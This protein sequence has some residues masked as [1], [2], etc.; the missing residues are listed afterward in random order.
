MYELVILFIIVFIAGCF[1]GNADATVFNWDNL[2][3]RVWLKGKVLFWFEGGYEKELSKKWWVHPIFWDGWHF[4]KNAWVTTLL[5]AIM[6]ALYSSPTVNGLCPV[7][8]F[9]VISVAWFLGKTLWHRYL[10]L[11]DWWDKK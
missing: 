2:V 10:A 7:I 8:Y 9:L 5:V 1:N 11:A 4:F 6:Y 3:W